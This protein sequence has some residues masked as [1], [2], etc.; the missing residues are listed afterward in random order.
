MDLADFAND[1]VQKGID[2]GL[3]ARHANKA[4]VST[5]SFLFCEECDDPIPAKRRLA[6]PGCALCV[7]C[8]HID[9]L[10]EAPHA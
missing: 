8:Q 4:A 5:H 1:L 9:E 3:A 2:Q 10:R 7:T 6:V